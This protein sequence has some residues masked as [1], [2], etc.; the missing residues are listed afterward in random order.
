[1]QKTDNTLKDGIPWRL[2]EPSN[3]NSGWAVLWLQGFTSTIE[4]HDEGVMRMSQDTKTTFAMLNYAGHGDSPIALEDATRKQQ[5]E[6]VCDV[7]DQLVGRGYS[8]IIVI[9][10]SFGGYMAAMLVGERTAATLVLRAPAN[11]KDEEFHLPYRQTTEGTDQEA[12][13]L[14]RQ[15]IDSNYSNNAIEAVRKFTGMTY[16]IEHE[17]DSVINSAIPKSYF[18]AAKK[19][20]YIVIPGLDHSPKLM[21][22]P[23]VY[24]DIIERWINTII[25]NEISNPQS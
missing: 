20:N 10:G 3:A 16:V 7:Y 13:D 9:G 12:K 1:M 5:F 15:S 4:G 2:Y 18:N 21:D 22:K 23:Q 19:A 6:E 8:K 17:K 24:F 14:W 25:T 11:Y